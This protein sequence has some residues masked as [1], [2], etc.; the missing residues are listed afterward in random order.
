MEASETDMITEEFTEDD[1]IELSYKSTSRQLARD[2]YDHSLVDKR[3]LN[4]MIADFAQQLIDD[5]NVSD[6]IVITTTDRNNEVAVLDESQDGNDVYLESFVDEMQN[7]VYSWSRCNKR[8]FGTRFQDEMQTYIFKIAH[9]ARQANSD[10][11]I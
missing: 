10:G 7:N 4:E 2:W 6:D 1:L 9:K 3:V 11:Q 8:E 5:R